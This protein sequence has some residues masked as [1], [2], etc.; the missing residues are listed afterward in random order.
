M[1]SFVSRS[2]DS[3]KERLTFVSQEEEEEEEEDIIKVAAASIYAGTSP[4]SDIQ[5]TKA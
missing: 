5:N 2:L 1:A 3:L 4:T